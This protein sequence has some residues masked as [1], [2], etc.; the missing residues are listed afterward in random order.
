M[1]HTPS[2]PTPPTYP[3]SQPRD[4]G[5]TGAAAAGSWRFA[6]GIHYRLG[7]P[8]ARLESQIAFTSL[9]ARCRDIQL[10][11]PSTELAY[12]ITPISAA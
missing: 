2:S 12:R 6:D 10:A 9:L 3:T 11:V 4:T 5:A 7:A 1:S 8:L